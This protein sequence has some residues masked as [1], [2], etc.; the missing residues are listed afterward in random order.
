ME[1]QQLIDLKHEVQAAIRGLRPW[2]ERAQ[3]EAV[4]RRDRARVA[5]LQREL[6]RLMAEETRL[7]REIDR[8]GR[9]EGSR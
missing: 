6:D 1:R 8:A 2:V 3:I 9:E 4:T 5:K 7:R